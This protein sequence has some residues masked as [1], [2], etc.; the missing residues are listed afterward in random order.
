MKNIRYIAIVISL[1]VL[2]AHLGCMS[3]KVAS[4]GA[5]SGTVTDVSGN[6]LSGVTV[7]TTEAETVSDVYG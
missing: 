2:V 6:S 1:I 7:S 4:P 3:T 5:I